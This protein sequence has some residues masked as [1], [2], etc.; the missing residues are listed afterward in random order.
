MPTPAIGCSINTLVRVFLT[1]ATGFIGRHLCLRL[2]ERGDHVVA[3]VRSQRK[4]AGLPREVELLQG[5]LS[6][7]ADPQTKLPA[8]EVVI[9]L[10][11]VVTADK[12]ADYEAVNCAA[13]KGLVECLGRQTWKPERLLFTSSLAAGGPTRGA[14][15]LTESDPCR[16]VDPYGKAK[17]RAEAIVREAPFPTTTFRPPIVLGPGDDASLTLFRAARTGIGFR[18]AGEPQGL[19]FVDVRDLVDA[20][21]LMASDRRPGSFCYYASHPSRTNVRE[22]WRELARSVGRRVFVVPV[23]AWLL[24]ALMRVSTAAAAVF[25]FKNRLDAKQYAQMTAPAFL[26]SSARLRAELGWAPK[27]D[28]AECIANAAQGYRAAGALRP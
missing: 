6:V 21:V 22:L 17:A 10:A 28:L 26:C 9:H 18:V 5:D 13:V 25:R 19:S 16:P 4:A 1:G 20:I 14:I 2:I 12:A 15:E 3:L 27:Y 8:S 11:G 24:Y 7:F 23:P